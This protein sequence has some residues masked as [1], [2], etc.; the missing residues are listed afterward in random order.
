MEAVSQGHMR[1]AGH[2]SSDL[3]LAMTGMGWQVTADSPRGMH[4]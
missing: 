4:P 1:M 2:C 3:P